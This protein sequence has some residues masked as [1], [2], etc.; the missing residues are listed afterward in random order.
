MDPVVVVVG[1][2]VPITNVAKAFENLAVFYPQDGNRHRR[3]PDRTVAPVHDSETQQRHRDVIEI[4]PVMDAVFGSMNIRELAVECLRHKEL[5]YAAYTDERTMAVYASK[6]RDT[7]VPLGGW[8]PPKYDIFLGNN[9]VDGYAVYPDGD[10]PTFVENGWEPEFQ[11]WFADKCETRGIDGATLHKWAAF[12]IRHGFYTIRNDVH[13][14]KIFQAAGR[15]DSADLMLAVIRFYPGLP[16]LAYAA[17]DDSVIVYATP[18][19]VPLYPL[20]VIAQYNAST[21]CRVLLRLMNDAAPDEYGGKVVVKEL[22]DVLIVDTINSEHCKVVAVFSEEGYIC[23]KL[24]QEVPHL[25]REQ[26]EQILRNGNNVIV[27]MVTTLLSEIIRRESAAL[28]ARIL[29]D[30]WK[31][32]D[33]SRNDVL[34]FVTRKCGGGNVVVFTPYTSLRLDRMERSVNSVCKEFFHLW[35]ATVKDAVAIFKQGYSLATGLDSRLEALEKAGPEA[36][37]ALY[38]LNVT[39]SQSVYQDRLRDAW[40]GAMKSFRAGRMNDALYRACEVAI[41]TPLDYHGTAAYRML[42]VL[43]LVNDRVGMQIV[44]TAFS[45]AHGPGAV[46]TLFDEVLGYAGGMRHDTYSAA[47]TENF[48][49]VCFEVLRWQQHNGT[50]AWR[51]VRIEH[52]YMMH[53][54]RWAACRTPQFILFIERCRRHLASVRDPT[55][56]CVFIKE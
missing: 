1:D 25:W 2:H 33:D 34:C 37:D 28:S 23:S 40:T 24:D 15:A 53:N 43:F 46:L 52:I 36:I 44:L 14:K 7:P 18:G 21:C 26:R 54:V 50:D 20:D 39:D 4:G 31:K 8:A 38:P 10:D 22:I 49:E 27:T 17:Y 56:S 5:Y 3:R 42:R 35:M 6:V 11:R 32:A 45:R 47:G 12:V 9:V 41:A 16:W 13:A 19:G 55:A 48:V 30:C 29:A 51:S